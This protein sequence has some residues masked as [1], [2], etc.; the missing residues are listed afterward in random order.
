MILSL[1]QKM[2]QVDS[3]NNGTISFDEFLML[4][5]QQASSKDEEEEDMKRVF[6]MFDKDG[7][8]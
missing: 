2:K 6:K 7:V 3:D 1:I 8:G 5:S 4:M